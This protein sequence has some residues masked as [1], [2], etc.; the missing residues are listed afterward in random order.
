MDKELYGG[1]G[2]YPI[3]DQGQKNIVGY[4]DEKRSLVPNEEY[5]LLGNHARNVN[6]FESS[7]TQGTVISAKETIRIL[8]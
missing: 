2:A 3:I 4:T 1:S 5:F 7:F 6:F 8:S